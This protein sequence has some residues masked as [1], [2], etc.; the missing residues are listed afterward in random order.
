MRFVVLR[1]LA[2]IGAGVTAL[3]GSVPSAQA[4]PV[5]PLKPPARDSFSRQAVLSSVAGVV[6]SCLDA[7]AS[8]LALGRWLGLVVANA[9]G[10]WWVC[11]VERAV[12]TA[13]QEAGPDLSVAAVAAKLPRSLSAS[14]DLEPGSAV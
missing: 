4:A 7:V 6:R 5:T 1:R 13:C 9:G 12:M 8:S 14:S 11:G 10:D 2:L 3:V